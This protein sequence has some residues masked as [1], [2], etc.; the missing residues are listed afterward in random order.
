MYFRHY[1]IHCNYAAR[2][3]FHQP[4]WDALAALRKRAIERLYRLLESQRLRREVC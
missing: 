3:E 2:R 1:G 4:F